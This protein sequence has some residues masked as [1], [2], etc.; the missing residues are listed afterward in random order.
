MSNI[1]IFFLSLLA[2]LD[3]LKNLVRLRLNLMS[4]S[5]PYGNGSV[6]LL[7]PLVPTSNG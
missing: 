7:P 4:I 5:L 3:S 1:V 6:R 2:F